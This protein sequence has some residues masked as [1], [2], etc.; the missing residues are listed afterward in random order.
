MHKDTQFQG[1]NWKFGLVNTPRFIKHCKVDACNP[2]NPDNTTHFNSQNGMI[3]N[4]SECDGCNICQTQACDE[5]YYLVN[6]NTGVKELPYI[7]RLCLPDADIVNQPTA[8]K[9]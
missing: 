6:K 1:E 3:T 5:S 4:S 8:M 2:F 7:C 9:Q